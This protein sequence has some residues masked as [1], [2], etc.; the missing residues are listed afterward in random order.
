MN[1]DVLL[2]LKVT[3]PLHQM[4]IMHLFK[5]ELHGGETKYST[6]HLLKFLQQ[7]NLEKYASILE[8]NGIDGD[9]I[10]EVEDK[11]M[12]N[13]LKEVGVTSQLDIL[14]IRSKYKT[15]CNEQ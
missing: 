10:L 4:K 7:Y 14:K 5:R 11:L 15:F 2:E 6:E 13:V 1:I 3:S 9:M 8:K 12:K